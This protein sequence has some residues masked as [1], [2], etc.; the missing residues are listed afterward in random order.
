MKTF[1]LA[2]SVAHCGIKPIPRGQGNVQLSSQR[3]GL[4]PIFVMQHSKVMVAV[5][6]LSAFHFQSA[7]SFLPQV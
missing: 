3:V 7:K 5:K 6:V 1:F 4:L 2:F